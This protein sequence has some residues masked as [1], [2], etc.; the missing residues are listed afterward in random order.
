MSFLFVIQ[1]EFINCTPL[2]NCIKSYFQH[3]T[4]VPSCNENQF[5]AT[6][7]YN[8]LVLLDKRIVW[9]WD[10]CNEI[11]DRIYSITVRFTSVY[12]FKERS[13]RNSK[14]QTSE[15]LGMLCS[16]WQNWNCWSANFVLSPL[17][18]MLCDVCDLRVVS[19]VS[20]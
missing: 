13:W 10:C 11:D 16:G 15:K 6:E 12:I 8:W 9:R 3:K 2:R 18:A 1:H 20:R 4:L 14:I 5:N 7:Q 19:Y 17:R